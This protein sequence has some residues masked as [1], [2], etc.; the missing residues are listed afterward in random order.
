MSQDTLSPLPLRTRLRFAT[1][2]LI[3]SMAAI[4]KSQ[5]AD[6]FKALHALEAR[7]AAARTLQ[8]NF[9]ERYSQN[10]KFVRAESGIAYFLRPGKMRWDYQ[11]PEKNLFLVDGVFSWFYSPADRTAV[12]VPEKESDDWRTPLAFLTSHAKISRLCAKVDLESGPAGSKAQPELPVPQDGELLF[13]CELRGAAK[14]EPRARVSENPSNGNQGNERSGATPSHLPHHEQDVPPTPTPRV[15]FAI[16]SDGELRRIVVHQEGG[17][18][19]EFSF[20][21]WN[22]NP[23]LDKSLFQFMPPRGVAIVNGLLPESPGLRQ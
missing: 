21:G 19:L 16:S 1:L 10:G 13:R 17:V 22:W 3:P 11:A 8:V 4:L 7:Y 12:R 15:W 20:T 6:Q 9:L 5:P 2:L 18:E 14:D 23:A